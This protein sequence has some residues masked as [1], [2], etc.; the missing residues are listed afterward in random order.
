SPATIP[1]GHPSWPAQKASRVIAVFFCYRWR[2]RAP[3]MTRAACAGR[4][5]ATASKGRARPSGRVSSPPPGSRGRRNSALAFSAGCYR[6]SR[7]KG[8]PYNVFD[9][10]LNRKRDGPERFLTNYHGYLHAD[11]FSGYD[12]LYLPD[13]RTAATRIIEVACNAHA[14]RKFYEARGSD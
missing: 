12:G 11:A 1:S 6:W 5:S 3:G 4:S 9:F 8:H 13:P 2:Y 10:T 7:A 14:R